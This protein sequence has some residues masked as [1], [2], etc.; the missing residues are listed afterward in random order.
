M[1]T[2]SIKDVAPTV[3]AILGLPSPAQSKAAVIPQI[4]QDLSDREHVAV[5]VPDALGLF[6]FRRWR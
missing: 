6:P 3:S 2:N 1:E 5:I 4:V